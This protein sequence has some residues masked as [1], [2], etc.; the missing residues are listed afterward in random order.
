M[1]MV[2]GLGKS[3]PADEALQT[4]CDQVRPEVEAREGRTFST[5]TAVECKTQVVSGTNYFI[6]VQV[7][8]DEFIHVRVHKAL[9]H[10]QG[11]LTLS[12]CQGGKTKQDEIL[13]F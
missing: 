8:D 4:L 5:F 9:P 3:K 1:A 13:H 10:E 11:K 7:S 12:A 6:K 2:G